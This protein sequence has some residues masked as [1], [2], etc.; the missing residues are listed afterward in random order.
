[1]VELYSVVILEM[2]VMT[3]DGPS[4]ENFDYIIVGA[5]SA[6]CVLANRLTASGRYIVL[7][8]EAGGGDRNP[9][10]HIPLGYAKH[11]TNPKVNWMYYAEEGVEWV[12]RAV[13]GHREP[14]ASHAVVQFRDRYDL[15][16]RP[17]AAK[18]AALGR[19]IMLSDL[20]RFP[21]HV[22]C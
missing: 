2:S 1:M 5:G 8:L 10:I 3:Q 14:R 15:P 6:G 16:F 11:F 12:K 22:R 20:Y 19:M 7:L 9:W 4:G 21:F 13:Y 18:V 17:R